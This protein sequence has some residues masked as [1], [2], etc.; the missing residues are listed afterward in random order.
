MYQN[1]N[2][3]KQQKQFADRKRKKAL[4]KTSNSTKRQKTTSKGLKTDYTISQSETD[5]VL[6]METDSDNFEE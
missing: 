6:Y 4:K 1:P 5:H 2:K 3:E